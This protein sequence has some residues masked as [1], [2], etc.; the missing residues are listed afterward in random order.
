MDKQEFL[1]AARE[2]LSEVESLTAEWERANPLIELGMA[3]WRE[4]DDELVRLMR[5]K[6][7][8]IQSSWTDIR[9]YLRAKLEGSMAPRRTEGGK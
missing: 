6:N 2:I 7:D 8:L 5:A 9:D 4:H 3:P 1:R